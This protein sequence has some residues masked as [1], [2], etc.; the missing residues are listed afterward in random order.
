MTHNVPQGFLWLIAGPDCDNKFG[1]GFE[2]RVNRLGEFSLP[3]FLSQ[4]AFIQI[5]QGPGP[6]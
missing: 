3:L 1:I 4:I 5:R 2:G 6:L